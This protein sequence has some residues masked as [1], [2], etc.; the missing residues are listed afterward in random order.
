MIASYGRDGIEVGMII[1]I[2]QLH[3]SQQVIVLGI[4]GSNVVESILQP[5]FGE[6]MP[7]QWEPSAES[8]PA[9]GLDYVI[10]RAQHIAV[11]DQSVEL[12]AIAGVDVKIDVDL[13]RRFARGRGWLN[14][15][16]VKAVPLE[17]I[18]N[19]RHRRGGVA[20]AGK[21]RRE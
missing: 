2:D 7:A 9:A 20:R 5:R 19:A 16:V 3:L 17:Q 21:A 15:G 12:G 6:L 8:L 1:Q 14:T 13:L 10:E 4:P 11:G 18:G